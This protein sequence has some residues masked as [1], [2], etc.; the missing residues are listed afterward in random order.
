[1]HFS[2]NGRSENR[3][4]QLQ[5]LVSIMNRSIILPLDTSKPTLA[6]A[7]GKGANLA[8][9]AQAGFPV[10]AG[11]VVATAAYD[12]FVAANDLSGWILNTIDSASPDDPQALE[13][14][15]GAIRARFATAHVPPDIASAISDVYAALDSPPVAVRSSATAEDLPGISF[16][17]QQDTYLNVVGEKDLLRAVVDCWSSLWTARAIG[18]RARNGFSHADVSLAV[19]VQEMVDSETS[20]VLFTANPLTGRRT[21]TVIEATLGLGEALV[22]GQ[23]EPDRYLVDGTGHVREK[24]LG[25]KARAIH[26][27][28][29]G[30]TAV[31]E[32]D[33]AQRQALPDE[34]ILELARLGRRVADLFGA[35]QD[36]EWA[37]VNGHF[38]ILQ[39]RP[40]TTLYP[41]PEGMGPEPLR[42]M[43][44]F[45][46]VQGMLDPMTPIGQDAMRVAF[47]GAAQ[48][49][50]RDYTEKTQPVL[51]LAG[52]RLW[53]D[54]TGLVRNRVG[55]R[56]AMAAL[57]F[58]DPVAAR[59]LRRVIEE[60][61]FPPPGN[62][63]LRTALHLLRLLVPM[64]IRAVR[65]LF[66]PD[67]ER[68]QM[69]QQIEA[70][71][72]GFEG[73]MS[74]TADL[75]ARV[76]LIRHMGHQ[77]FQYVI[78]QFVPR[79]GMGMATLNLLRILAS[80]LPDGESKVLA[81][82]RGLPHDVTTEMDLALWQIAQA[83]R[84]DPDAA[85][86]CRQTDAKTLATEYRRGQ[87]PQAAQAA[88][89][90]FMARYGVRG[91]AE[92]DLGRPRWHEDPAPVM[93]ALQSYLQIAAADRA[94]DVAF[95]R[96]RAAAEAGI[97]Q[98]AA[99]VR[100][101]RGGWVKSR[102]VRWA[103]H[104]M[105][106]LAGLRESPK[107]AAVRI[108]G[109][110]RAALLE[111][112]Q[113]LVEKGALSQPDDVCFLYLA[114]LEVLAAD[115]Q[116]DW[117]HLIQERRQT[118]ARERLRRQTPRLLLS[119][120]QAF[121]ESGTVTQADNEDVITGSPVSPGV[122]EGTVHVVLD[123]HRAQLAPGEILVCPGT[124]PSWT[125]LFLA[126]GGLV[127]EVGGMMT[128]GSVVAREYG[129]PAVVGVHE[130]TRRLHTGQRIRV[131]GNSG[132]I[133]ILASMEQ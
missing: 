22:S 106:A 101:T 37:R 53:I 74:S 127:M 93:Q 43:A 54:I 86:H 133:A 27:R 5:V 80:D 24:T 14:T 117:V 91:L 85:A 81:L 95:E 120:G 88:V 75:Q 82:T 126:A 42:V 98:L 28:V 119:D 77:V 66:R 96:G 90:A 8:R 46:A 56:L 12:A 25:T 131:D 102:L 61:R 29:G 107:F 35:P 47:V 33:A 123:P 3:V 104:R 130:A 11:F 79:F 41:L 69:E 7:G 21:E 114:E 87:L 67:V 97:E 72:G 78:P 115:E 99:A 6:D 45:G 44:S 63:R 59:A 71:V 55:R 132:Q 84:A 103:A 16:A 92:I 19:V 124:D 109:I 50:G 58:V 116:R 15:S 122:V 2:Y 125:P 9:L 110:M 10:P 34:A 1:M 51:R 40:I 60:G 38:Y 49:F 13:E 73:R 129:I 62:L 118:Y 36:A 105:R 52:E 23:V 4:R 48:L 64:A 70:L 57:P 89:A 108:F 121:Y 68:R 30:G 100:R 18:Y 31:I 17:G 32:Q 76:R 39:S 83:I 128:H 20:G 113:A 112:G 26:A 111:S 94:P 65:A